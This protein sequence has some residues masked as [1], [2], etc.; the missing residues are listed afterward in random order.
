MGKCNARPHATKR[1]VESA[2][3]RA[4]APTPPVR[5]IEGLY[6]IPCDRRHRDHGQLGDALA[7]GELDGIRPV[8]DQENADLA[9]VAGVDEPRPIDDTYTQS[10][11]VSRTWKH[12]TRMTLGYRNCQPGRDRGPLPRL[13]TH[14]DSG[15]KI[16]G[17]VAD[18]C[19]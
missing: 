17:R 10:H 2:T 7:S 14:I 3:R 13:E 12:E 8:V 6:P 11:G 15:V 5:V 16:D 19:C 9:P 4:E 18:M 1:V